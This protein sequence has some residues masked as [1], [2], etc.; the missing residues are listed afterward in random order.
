MNCIDLCE[1]FRP[2]HQRDAPSGTAA[3][4]R[5]E[6]LLSPGGEVIIVHNYGLGVRY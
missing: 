6:D 3:I 1:T 4:S 2:G 5:A